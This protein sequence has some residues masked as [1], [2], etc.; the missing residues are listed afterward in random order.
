MSALYANITGQLS[1]WF[2]QIDLALEGAHPHMAGIDSG[3][4]A[5]IAFT[6]I[7]GAKFMCCGTGGK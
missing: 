3:Q 1:S 2:S 4:L 7:V 6:A 5:L